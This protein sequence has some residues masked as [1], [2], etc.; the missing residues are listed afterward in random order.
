M[1]MEGSW[2]PPA[3]L[4]IPYLY[5]G[6]EHVGDLGL[7]I[8]TALF[9]TLDPALGRWW[10]IDPKAE[11]FA[12]MTPYNS[13]GN[14]PVIAVDPNGDFV[15][16]TVLACALVGGIVNT[17][18]QGLSGKINS[19]K[20]FYTAFGM[21]ALN[22]ALVGMGAGSL[23]AGINQTLIGAASSLLPSFSI[24]NG[25][26]N[27]S[28]SPSF[29]LG[30]SGFSIGAN[31][32]LGI[33]VGDV[34]AGIG[35]GLSEYSNN[36]STG[37]IPLSGTEFRASFA[38]GVVGQDASLLVGTNTFSSGI[39]SQQTGIIRASAG[40]F[41]LGYENDGAPFDGWG[42]IPKG[43]DGYRTAALS[44]GYK[45]FE[46]ECKLFTGYRD[47]NNA[48][49]TLDGQGHAPYGWV[50]NPEINEY[51]LG[52]VS[53]GYKGYKVGWNSDGI[54]HAVQNQFAHDKPWGRPQAWIPC[55]RLSKPF[56]EYRPNNRFTYW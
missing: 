44:L 43:S 52:A 21:G 12:G 54:R 29:M 55:M 18:I 14:N 51:R 36:Y 49:P 11:S 26:F 32:N 56:L 27:F 37:G 35:F 4:R 2:S 1:Q 38:A 3:A 48:K 7:D 39:S 41:H 19:D 9:R 17:A 8:N 30:T 22:G 53:I 33:H 47:F 15:I 50:G 6:I 24:G 10:Q 23:S 5:N 13:M 46:L 20:D 42:L 31:L 25:S 34:Y 40:G 45:D 16:E 28:I